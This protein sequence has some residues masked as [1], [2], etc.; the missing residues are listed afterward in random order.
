M[1]FTL[2]RLND[3]GGGQSRYGGLLAASAFSERT[4]FGHQSELYQPILKS[5]LRVG[6]YARSTLHLLLARKCSLYSLAF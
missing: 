5:R 6:I 2:M 4:D 3:F 1:Y